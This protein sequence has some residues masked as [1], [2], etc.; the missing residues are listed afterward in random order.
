M[1]TPAKVAPLLLPSSSGALEV[2]VGLGSL[3]FSPTGVVLAVAEAG[4]FLANGPG[5]AA[6]VAPVAPDK[7]RED[8]K[9]AELVDCVGPILKLLPVGQH[10]TGAG[11]EQKPG[12]T[13][14]P[15]HPC[16]EV[17]TQRPGWPYLHHQTKYGITV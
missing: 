3:A 17:S 11:L 15:R 16:S 2:L 9:V 5:A 1:T 13:R 10:W 7:M 12:L 4:S 8:V 14:A 6:A